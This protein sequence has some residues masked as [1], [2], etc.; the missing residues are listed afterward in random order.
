M[1]RKRDGVT[2]LEA[3]LRS[4]HNISYA[5]TRG[6]L[7]FVIYKSIIKRIGKNLCAPHR[8]PSPTG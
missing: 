5:E 7:L 6:R 8:Y 4:G 3:T 1:S 2:S